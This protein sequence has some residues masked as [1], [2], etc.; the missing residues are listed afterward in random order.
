MEPIK[1]QQ[2]ETGRPGSKTFLFYAGCFVSFIVVMAVLEKV[3]MPDKTLGILFIGFTILVY[4][5]I[6]IVARTMRVSEFYLAGQTVPPVFNGLAAAAQWISGT[7]FMTFAGV[8]YL[9]GYAGF[10]FVL[11]SIGGFVLAAIL[12]VPY[13]R[14]SGAYTVPAFLAIRFGGPGVGLMGV[15]VLV[16]ASFVLMVAQ[17]QA[18]GLI[19][20]QFLGLAYESGT[21]LGAGCLV[22]CTLL[23]G[24]RAVT[25]AQVAQC[26]ILVIA[27]LVPIAMISLNVSGNPLAQIT[28]GDVLQKVSDIEQQMTANGIAAADSLPVL[29]APDSDRLNF[30]ALILCLMIGAASMPHLLIRFCTV[31]CTSDARK[32]V[33]WA[34]VFTAVLLLTVPAYAAFVKLEIYQSVIGRAVI[35]L[36]EWVYVWGQGNRIQI[37]GQAA[38]SFDAVTSACRA[39]GTDIVRLS[40]FIIA[41][42]VVV[43]AAPEIAGLPYVMTGLIGAGALAAALASASGLLLAMAN[44]ISHDAF[45]KAIAPNAPTGRRLFV[46]R[47]VLLAMAGAGFYVATLATPDILKLFAWAFSIAAAGNFPALVLGIWWRRCTVQGA[48]L[49]MFAGLATTLAYII[50]TEPALLGYDYPLIFGVHNNAAGLFGLPVGLLVVI[51]VSLLTR[52]PSPE[53]QKRV[54]DI[55]LPMT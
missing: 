51:G 31:S 42:D 5:S 27:F 8:L 1:S 4:V 30:F 6:G 26:V 48:M 7:A 18:T 53:Q 32:S 23:G 44:S 34:L 14:N 12:I 25:W 11:G 54:W 9:M 43:M 21:A 3:G 38:M 37:C 22:L 35:D 24:M 40:D 52:A 41:R 33:S 17:I 13:L 20:E 10:A 15:V 19:A 46:A 28:Y 55:R 50:G 39:A 49:G 16:T 2:F 47:L 29:Q 45:H 36:P